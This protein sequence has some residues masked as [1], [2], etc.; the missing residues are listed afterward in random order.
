MHCF[1]QHKNSVLDKNDVDRSFVGNTKSHKT[2]IVVATI[3]HWWWRRG[4]RHSQYGHCGW[5]FQWKDI[6]QAEEL[7][8]EAP[9]DDKEEEATTSVSNI[10]DSNIIV[11]YPPPWKGQDEGNANT[12]PASDDC[13]DTYVFP[14]FRFSIFN[15]FLIFSK[16]IPLSVFTIYIS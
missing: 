15:Q 8:V 5:W 1:Y 4:W 3:F 12:L 11:D 10:I 13:N 16:Y 9:Q 7:F 6:E 2:G 14:M